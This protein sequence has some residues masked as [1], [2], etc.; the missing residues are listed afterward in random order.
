MCAPFVKNFEKE[1]TIKLDALTEAIKF[2]VPKFELKLYT[3]NQKNE[4]LYV[5]PVRELLSRTACVKEL[6]DRKLLVSGVYFLFFKGVNE[7]GPIY[8]PIYV[9]DRGV[10]RAN[11][12][13]T[14]LRVKFANSLQMSVLDAIINEIWGTIVCPPRERCMFINLAISLLNRR[15]VVLWDGK[16][17]GEMIDEFESAIREDDMRRATAIADQINDPIVLCNAIENLAVRKRHVN[18]VEELKPYD[19]KSVQMV[20]SFIEKL[21]EKNDG[22]DI[23]WQVRN[24][25]TKLFIGDVFISGE[26]IGDLF[27]RVEAQY[28]HATNTKDGQV[29]TPK[30][31]WNLVLHL[32]GSLF[33]DNSVIMDPTAGQGNFT[34]NVAK[35]L[36]DNLKDNH[37]VIIENDINEDNT[38]M[39]FIRAMCMYNTA[40]RTC[41]EDCFKDRFKD[42]VED[43]IGERAVDFLFMNP[44]FGIANAKGSVKIGDRMEKQTE[45]SFVYYNMTTF[46]KSGARFLFVLPTSCVSENKRNTEDKRRFLKVAHL[47]YVIKVR[48][49][50]FAG[51]GASKAV[52]LLVGTYYGGERFNRKYKTRC[53]DMSDDG[54]VIK[55]KNGKYIWNDD[56][57]EELYETVLNDETLETYKDRALTAEDN[58]VYVKPKRLSADELRRLFYKRVCDRL[59]EC[60]QSTIAKTDFKMTLRP[61]TGYAMKTFKVL[62]LFEYVGKGKHAPSTSND[63]PYPLISCSTVNNGIVKYIDEFEF[64]GLYITMTADGD[65]CGTS[66]VQRGK[67]AAATNVYVMKPKVELSEDDLVKISALITF[68]LSTRYN[69]TNKL[70]STRLAEETVDLPINANDEIDFNNYDVLDMRDAEVV[71]DVPITDLFEIMPRGSISDIKSCNDG[72]YP[73]VQCSTHNNGI[74]RFIDTYAYDGDYIT[75]ATNGNSSAGICFVQHGKFNVTNNVNVLKPKRP[76]IVPIL[77]ELAFAMTMNFRLKGYSY[78]TTLNARRL[79]EEVIPNLPFKPSGELDIDGIRYVY[80]YRCK[81]SSEKHLMYGTTLEVYNGFILGERPTDVEMTDIKISDLFELVDVKGYKLNDLSDGDYPL[82]MSGGVNNGISRYVD[83]FSY[84]ATEHPVITNASTGTV[85]SC[86]VQYDKFCIGESSSHPP[87]VI[88]LKPSHQYLE[89]CLGLLAFLMTRKFTQKYNYSTKLNNARLMKE[90]ITLPTIKGKLNANLL[91]AWVY[92]TLL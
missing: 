7:D 69:W 43:E 15:D 90:T 13:F 22:R 41:N 55:E 5:I 76:E 82:I 25:R 18:A 64:D 20:R 57:L 79:S 19:Q 1:F 87:T 60:M 49:D 63:G 14:E 53:A 67:F 51:S 2:D 48:E 21:L 3:K 44:P 32:Y 65:A 4:T 16:S 81:T 11:I 59:H 9:D 23:M 35:Y 62:D 26:D 89:S 71:K 50:I 72:E 58:W 30:L 92:D 33:K 73:L 52:C 88:K 56:E 66:F 46:C 91:N 47:E 6:R 83:K 39:T 80:V 34:L 42:T 78:S 74:V 40:I 85:G 86:F 37:C 17:L 31:I 61:T 77:S 75:V 29:F 27:K 28:L 45:W 68:D 36:D 70:N 10:D 54:G 12:T 38:L 84:D 8:E 24:I